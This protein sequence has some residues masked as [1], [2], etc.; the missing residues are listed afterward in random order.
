MLPRD[1]WEFYI[2]LGKGRKKVLLALT[3]MSQ[4]DCEGNRQMDRGWVVNKSGWR[5]DT[6]LWSRKWGRCVFVCM[7]VFQ[8]GD[9]S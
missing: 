3:R 4:L 5:V 7:G 2:D 6:G 8:S 9:P 1:W